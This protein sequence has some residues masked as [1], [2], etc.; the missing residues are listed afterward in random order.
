MK[1]DIHAA[2]KELFEMWQSGLLSAQ[3]TIAAQEFL[4]ELNMRGI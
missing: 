4:Y 3:E 2:W 1:F